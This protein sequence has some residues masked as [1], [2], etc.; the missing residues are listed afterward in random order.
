MPSVW[1][2][3]GYGTMIRIGRAGHGDCASVFS[4][5]AHN[6]AAEPVTNVRR[7]SFFIFLPWYPLLFFCY[8][9]G[10]EDRAGAKLAQN[11]P[12]GVV[13]LCPPRLRSCRSRSSRVTSAAWKID[14]MNTH[15]DQPAR[16]R[17]FAIPSAL[18]RE[19]SV[20]GLMSSISAAPPGP[21]TVRNAFLINSTCSG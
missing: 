6:S 3:A 1:P 19:A 21:N 17:A 9:A 15:P 2:P 7:V 12:P 20:V 14:A 16:P 11:A 4:D 8:S 10:R 13:A 18:M 5:G